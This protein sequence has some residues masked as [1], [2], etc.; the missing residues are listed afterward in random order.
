MR[1][2]VLVEP[3]DPQTGGSHTFQSQ[4]LEALR[5]HGR[6]KGH[7]FVLLSIFPSTT[8]SEMD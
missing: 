2:G 6:G 7:T 4:V 5:I 8:N 1:I 3:V